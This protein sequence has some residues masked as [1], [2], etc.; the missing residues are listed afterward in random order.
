MSNAALRAFRTAISYRFV[1]GLTE[2]QDV[3]RR[4]IESRGYIWA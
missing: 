3:F 4:Y 1:G 2:N